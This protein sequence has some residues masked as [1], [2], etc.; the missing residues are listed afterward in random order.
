MGPEGKR[1]PCNFNGLRTGAGEI[2]L[3]F[4]LCFSIC[5]PHRNEFQSRQRERLS[6]TFALLDGLYNLQC[7][8]QLPV[9]RS[10]L[11]KG[12]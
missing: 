5:F 1:V 9:G 8:E 2:E 11:G 4:Y 12:H 3:K 6:Q 7:V 10:S